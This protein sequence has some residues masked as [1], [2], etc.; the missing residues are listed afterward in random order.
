MILFKHAH[1]EQGFDFKPP[2]SWYQYGGSTSVPGYSSLWS[3]VIFIVGSCLGVWQLVST[4]PTHRATRLSLFADL[5]D[6]L[7]SNLDGFGY[8]EVQHLLMLASPIGLLLL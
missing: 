1:L 4:R 2:D 6:F 8:L 7:Q 5:R 3:H